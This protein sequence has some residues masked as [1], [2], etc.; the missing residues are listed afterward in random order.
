MSPGKNSKLFLIAAIAVIA[1]NLRPPITG[2]G[3]LIYEIRDDTGLS[4]T[5]LGML[6]TLPVLA[7]GVFSVLTPLFTR[8]FGTEG[9]M[10]FALVLLT[11]GTL[12]RVIP[13]SFAL[14]LGTIVLGI[15]IALGNVLMP[16]IAKK[17]F[18]KRFGM[19]TGIYAAMF[20]VGS[21]LASGISVPLSEGLD[22]GW[23]WALGAWAGFSFLALLIWIPQLKEN[24]PVIARNNLRSS[25]KYLAASKSAW[26]VAIFMGMQALTFYAITAWLPEILID[27]GMSPVRAGWLLSLLQFMGVIGTFIFPAWASNLSQQRNPILLLLLFEM[28]CLAGLIMQSASYLMVIIFVSVLGISVGGSFGMALLFIGLRTRDTDAA[29][30]LSGMA[31]SVGYTLAA[32]GPTLLGGLHDLARN[33]TIPLIFLLLISLLKLWSGWGAAKNRFV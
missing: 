8:K 31:Q 30:E 3:P 10:A 6:T 33:W 21:A 16:G 19:V 11:A 32:T 15:G 12:F 29:N 28:I 7:F 13:T 2:V 27:R 20:G 9:T 26:Y 25:L 1:I 23:R 24:Q 4:N 14:F 17:K 5:L 22:F 18:P